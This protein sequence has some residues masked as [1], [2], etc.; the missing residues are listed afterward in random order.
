MVVNPRTESVSV[1]RS[2]DDI[3]I[4]KADEVLDG[5]DVVPGWRLTVRDLFV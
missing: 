1:Y 2:R 5:A 3:R 4:L